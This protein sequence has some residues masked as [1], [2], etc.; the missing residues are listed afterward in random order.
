MTLEESGPKE[1]SLYQSF[2]RSLPYLA[3]TLGVVVCAMCAP[4]IVQ[5]NNEEHYQIVEFPD[6]D[7]TVVDTTGFHVQAFG[8]VFTYPRY[9][10]AYLSKSG[11]ASSGSSRKGDT[12]VRVT[13]N[14]G[15][16]GFMSNHLKFQ[17]PVTREK[18]IALH[19]HF[20]EG[21]ESAIREAIG[22][23]LINCLKN[24][25]PLMSGSEHQSQRKAEFY[26]VVSDQ[27]SKGLYSMERVKQK[28][29]R[30]D[31]IDG[32]GEDQDVQ[33]VTRIKR[34][35][36]G[37]PI[38]SATSPLA[39]Y[40]ITVVQYNQ[41]D[42]VYDRDTES[43]INAK[44][45]SYQLA[46]EAKAGVEKEHQKLQ[47]VVEKGRLAVANVEAEQQKTKKGILVNAQK[48]L[49]VKRI[50][51]R[52]QVTIAEQAVSIAG[53]NLKQVT[54]ELETS[55]IAVKIAE[56]EAKSLISLSEATRAKLD[57]G[58]ALSEREKMLAEMRMHRNMAIAKSISEI[59]SPKTVILSEKKSGSGETSSST[60]E[61]LMNLIML[62]QLKQQDGTERAR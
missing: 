59:P 1:K 31:K 7:I 14:D 42:T 61:T 16:W 4:L 51:Q 50:N 15:G 49:D 32:F 21:G 47:E 38:L 35:A 48:D 28:I 54:T 58:G 45:N 52:E 55:K 17:M 41:T 56:A 62:Q 23:H 40:G 8:Q 19:R 33:Y 30:G 2:D 5:W 57:Q 25:G 53:E 18:R 36:S 46:E 39:E 10:D 12:S 13:F 34:D 26:Q 29:E 9:V 24:T 20:G 27:L 44:R 60:T 37:Q 22:H 3:A 11:D 6:G 43:Q